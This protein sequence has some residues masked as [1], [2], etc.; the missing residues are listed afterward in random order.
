MSP[1]ALSLS[2]SGTTLLVTSSILWGCWSLVC[3]GAEHASSR[4]VPAALQTFVV[5]AAMAVVLVPLAARERATSSTTRDGSW[6]WL[7]LLGLTDA[8][9]SLSFFAAMQHT[10][11]AVAVLCHYAAPLL[12]ARAAPLLLRERRVK[13]TAGALMLAVVGVVLVLRPWVAVDHDDVVGAGLGL[14][15]AVFYAASVLIGKRLVGHRGNVEVAGWPKLVSLPVIA[16]AVVAGGVV[17]DVEPLPLAI[18]VGGGVVCGALPLLL[19]YAGLRRLPAS[20]ASVLTL[21]EPVTAV[22]IG[23]VVLREPLT[24]SVAVGGAFVLV[25]VA[26]VARTARG[27]R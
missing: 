18:L 5:V 23:V 14:L 15:S 13:G 2:T 16:L 1:S 6:R 3:R 7:A 20:Q 9:N 22:A 4:P 17:V 8:L 27:G 26:L 12:V 11:V 19:F 25:G 21:V 24:W 10:S